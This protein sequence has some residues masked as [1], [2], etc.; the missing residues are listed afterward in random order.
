[1]SSASNRPSRVSHRPRPS[2][3][4]PPS[5]FASSPPPPRPFPPPSSPSASPSASSSSPTLSPSSTVR[6]PRTAPGRLWHRRPRRSGFLPGCRGRV[7]MLRGS[8]RMTRGSRGD[9]RG[10]R[11]RRDW[12]V[13]GGGEPRGGRARWDGRRRMRRGGEFRCWVLRWYRCR[14]Q[15]RMM[16]LLLLLFHHNLLLRH[17]YYSH[18]KHPW[19]ASPHEDIIYHHSQLSAIYH[20]PLLLSHQHHLLRSRYRAYRLQRWDVQ[21]TTCGV[22]IDVPSPYEE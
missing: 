22:V 14:N 17:H 18:T 9:D 11:R 12:R 2:P 4:L 7:G 13:P 6:P 3:S 21:W 5:V 15:W 1:M 10:S 20:H 16:L 19:T 8:C